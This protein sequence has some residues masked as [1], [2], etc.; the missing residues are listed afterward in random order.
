MGYGKICIDMRLSRRK[1][2]GM[3]WEI[4]RYPRLTRYV[5]KTKSY[6]ISNP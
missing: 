4:G 3:G 5:E 2:L 1:C 6:V